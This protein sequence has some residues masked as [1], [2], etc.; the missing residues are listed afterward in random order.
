MWLER[1]GVVSG[2]CCKE[3][4][5]YP[6][7]ITYPYSTCIALFCGSKKKECQ[8]AIFYFA[9]CVCKLRCYDDVIYS[10]DW[11][12]AVNA[13]VVLKMRDSVPSMRYSCVCNVS[14]LCVYGESDS[15]LLVESNDSMIH[16]NK[17]RRDVISNIASTNSILTPTTVCSRGLCE[18]LLPLVVSWGVS[19]TE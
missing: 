13:M 10:F 2:C 14:R 9:W 6:H 3:V 8:I 12:S 18:L 7:I 4:Y 19:I 16:T 11:K 17:K 15:S 5:R 1:I